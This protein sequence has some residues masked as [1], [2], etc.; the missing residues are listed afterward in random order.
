MSFD[1]FF[2]SFQINEYS[3]WYTTSLVFGLISQI[4][5]YMQDLWFY[6]TCTCIFVNNMTFKRQRYEALKY[7]FKVFSDLRMI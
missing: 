4:S 6:I 3:M 7:L 1:K 2:L 5:I